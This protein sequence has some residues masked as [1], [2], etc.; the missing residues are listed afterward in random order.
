MRRERQPVSWRLAGIDRR[1][2]RAGALPLAELEAKLP[3]ARSTGHSQAT[4]AGAL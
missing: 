4:S 2:R 3:T 1:L